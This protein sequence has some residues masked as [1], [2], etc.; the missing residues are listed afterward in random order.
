MKDCTKPKRERGSCYECG[1]HGHISRDCPR[2]KKTTPSAVVAPKT[3][4]QVSNV[5]CDHVAI[6]NEYVKPVD[7]A[8][9]KEGTNFNFRIDS[10][11]DTASP[12][13]LIKEK[14]VPR[15]WIGNASAEY[16][17]GINSSILDIKGIVRLNIMYDDMEAKSVSLRVV[18]DTA[19]KNNALL[20]RDALRMLGLGL[21]K[22]PSEKESDQKTFEEILNIESSAFGGS[23][24]DKIEINP[25]LM[26]EEN[27]RIKEKNSKKISRGNK[28]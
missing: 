12:I 8:K 22:L 13:S 2:K 5:T 14:L 15:D 11:F 27:E 1:I 4:A 6:K 23:E 9:E 18:A 10:Q 26:A 21:T 16:Y 7:Y 20:G 19:M 17:E 28:T 24:I 25:E 3:D